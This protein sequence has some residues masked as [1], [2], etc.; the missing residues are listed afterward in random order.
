MATTLPELKPPEVGPL[1][2]AGQL[3]PVEVVQ[4]V[5]DR[6]QAG[7]PHLHATWA[8]DADTALAM[9]RAPEGRWRAGQALG[10]LDGVPVT[11]KENIAT[12]GLPVPLGSAV[13]ALQPAAADA[14]PAA[15][16]REA[17]AVFI[18]R[19]TMPDWGMLSSGLSSF[20]ALARNPWDLRKNPGGSSAGA[21]GGAAA[22]HGAPDPGPALRRALPPAAPAPGRRRPQRRATGRGTWPPTSADRSA[23]R[24]AGAAWSASSPAWAAFPSSR[25]TPAAWPARSPARSPMR[26]WR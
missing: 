14:P 2:G 4:S 7:E 20:H 11:L 23:C 25:L 9:A 21:A 18:A 1:Y 22:G 10:P 24:P 15:R 17:G 12:R 6:V 5:V 16:L 13:T 3:S 26:C 19:T 8:F